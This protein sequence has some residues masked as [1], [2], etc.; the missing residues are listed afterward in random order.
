[1]NDYQTIVKGIVDIRGVDD[2]VAEIERRE[3]VET[4]DALVRSLTGGD[5]PKIPRV[6]AAR[7][8]CHLGLWDAKEWVEDNFLDHG[9]GDPIL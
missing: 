7:I 6:K 4:V 9:A 1:M 5:K 2:L 3:R 8:L